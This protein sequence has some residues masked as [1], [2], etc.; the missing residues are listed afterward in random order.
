MKKSTQIL[1]LALIAVLAASCATQQKLKTIREGQ[2]QNVQ[3]TLAD[4]VSY[5]PEMKVENLQRDTLTIKDDDGTEILIMKA[6]KDEESGEMVATDVIEAAKV[7]ARF[8]NVAER[9]GKIDLGFQI[10]VPESMIDSKW[11]LRFYPDMFIME[12]SIRLEPVIITGEK[13][14]N[15]QL[16]GYQQYERFLSKI[17]SDTTIFVNVRALEIFIKR[18]IPEVYAFKTDST[19]VSDEQFFSVYGVSEQE[20]VDHYTNKY[21]KNMN[22]RRKARKD[23]MYRKYIKAPIV[24]EGLRL[25]SIITNPDGDFVYHYV[26]TIDTRPKLRKVDIVLSGEIYEQDVRLYTIPEVP[27]L[28][29]YIS[30]ISAFADNTERY[31]TKV[32]ERRASANTE[33]KIAFELGKADIKLEL[34][35]NLYEIQKIK[36]TLASLL[37]NETFDLDSILVSATASP[38]GSVATNRKLSNRRSESVSKYFNEF[39]SEYKDSLI[40]EGGVSMNMDGT[41]MEY[42]TKVQDIRFTPRSIPENW[43]DLYNMVQVNL[44]LTEEAIFAFNK[45]YEAHEDLDKRERVLSQEP[46]Y[47]YLRDSL[48]PRLRTVKFNFFLHRKGMVKDTVHTTV[49]DSTYMNGVQAL[50]EMDYNTAVALL[51]P[52]NDYNTAVAYMG[53][54][55]NLSALQ[56]LEDMERTPQVNYL[57]AVLYSRTG[58]PQKAVQCYM[59]ACKA[60]RSYVYRGNLDP[61]ISVLIK[62]YGLNQ[63][64]EE[65]YDF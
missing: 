27:P 47:R 20:A 57:L 5:L 12:D 58:D 23:E 39:M 32:I 9:R 59:N 35:D 56:I 22:E 50:R 34:A 14:R 63:E 1:I 37:N 19:I 11:Q 8:R 61:E 33:C 21:A 49:L 25:D 7:T 31:L 40:I 45:I 18:N 54:D 10:I 3:L 62:T 16:K 64:P 28:T 26:Q 13:Y 29:F 30:S 24:S 51:R 36:T 2:V 38:E 48:Y 65:E 42:T 4:D 17:I 53:M 46:Y 15:T 44:D 52:Y 41:E 43:E 6:I 60:D 55:R